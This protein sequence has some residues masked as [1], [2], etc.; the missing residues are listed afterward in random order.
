MVG[1]KLEENEK[2]KKVK[3]NEKNVKQE[4][5]VGEARLI[6]KEKVIELKNTVHQN[7]ESR[8]KQ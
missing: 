6:I 4:K 7:H 8:Q 3:E 5:V 1:K 2:L